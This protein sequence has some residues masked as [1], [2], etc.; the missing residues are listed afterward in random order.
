MPASKPIALH[1]CNWN[2]L[3]PAISDFPK[4]G[5][6]FR[7]VSPLMAN[8]AVLQAVIQ[9]FVNRLS[10]VPATHV[11]GLDARGFVFGSLLASAM[12]LPFVMARKPSKLPGKVETV[13]YKLEYG[14]SSIQMQAG[15]VP[16]KSQ[17]IIVDDILATG[18]T[19]L[20]AA[21]LV[22]RL[23][24]QVSAFC[25]VAEIMGLGGRENLQKQINVPQIIL[26]QC[27]SDAVTYQPYVSKWA[28]MQS[29]LAKSD[30]E[31]LP[32][33]DDDSNYDSKEDNVSEHE[34]PFVLLFHPEMKLLADK[35]VSFHPH[36][37]ETRDIQWGHFPD[38][39]PDL[40]FPTDLANRRV[41]FL[42]SLLHRSNLF[43]QQSVAM[44]LPRQ[45]IQSLDIY[46][47][48]YST[49]TMEHITPGVVAT[50]DTLAQMMS[51]CFPMTKEGSASFNTFDIHH[52]T[53]R[54][55]FDNRLPLNPMT[56][57]PLLLNE[58]AGMTAGYLKYA[59][60]FPDEGSF[61]RFR[62][63]IPTDIP[64]IVCGK[65]R[66]GDERRVRLTDYPEDMDFNSLDHVVIV[67]DIVRSGGTLYGCMQALQDVGCKRISAFVPHAVFERR[68]YLHF[69]PGGKW[70][71]L[72]RFYITDS[73]PEQAA[74]LHG[75][76]PFRALSLTSMIVKDL[77]KRRPISVEQFRPK[78]NVFVASQ[79]QVKLDAVRSAFES[80]YCSPSWKIRVHGCAADSKVPQQPLNQQI[81]EGARNRLRNLMD[82]VN[83]ERL[84]QL[85]RSQGFLLKRSR[86]FGNTYDVFVSF[87]SGIQEETTLCYDTARVLVSCRDIHGETWSQRVPVDPK[88][89]KEWQDRHGS[90]PNLTVGQ[91]YHEHFHVSANDWQGLWRGDSRMHLLSQ[92]LV[93]ILTCSY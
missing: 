2:E 46:M 20:A 41:I 68:E 25:C 65:M 78:I 4:P 49:G 9:E 28:S 86:K 72:H 34:K 31:D 53:I 61:K 59:L 44:V 63:L 66:K 67:D 1:E 40:K 39:W 5:I 27:S 12:N 13:E 45:S 32:T 26:T 3:L 11:V 24:G 48:M 36:L 19:L 23:A 38:G 57:V 42:G 64:L 29:M 85:I 90:E 62:N 14:T 71:G 8:P 83:D 91:I 92:A 30:Y 79:Q 76:G 81:D 33:L 87:E 77:L 60:A 70:A 16:P 7:D 74:K 15:A 58:L 75:H 35:L 56:A 54:G 18:G 88:I 80:W 10:L 50:A 73:I 84:D 55:F 93:N 21:E 17:V 37:F 52:S 82:R 51:S 69:M 43:E 47:P 89:W 22:K 6:T